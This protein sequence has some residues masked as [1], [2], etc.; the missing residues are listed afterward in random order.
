[1]PSKP[2]QALT[3]TPWVPSPERRQGPAA[4]WTLLPPRRA[5]PPSWVACATGWAVKAALVVALTQGAAT[6]YAQ[7][8]VTDW[9]QAHEFAKEAGFPSHGVIVGKPG[10]NGFSKECLDLQTFEQQV[11]VALLSG[12]VWLETDM[13][14][15]RNPTRM[16]MIAQCAQE[17]SRL[18]Q[19][20]CPSCLRPG[21]GE[22]TPIPG[23]V[24]Q[25]CG[26][27]TT[28]LR[29]KKTTCNACGYAQE[30]LLQAT[31]PASRCERCNP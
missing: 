12:P 17:L 28:A 25:S 26:S 8:T 6:N 24:C 3:Q 20:Q 16:A 21:F 23:A 15:H 5:S 2:S 31:V 18:L 22:D 29:A 4:S 1:M 10:Q 30:V 19:C 7:S 14:A 13:R 27:L 11:G 9:P